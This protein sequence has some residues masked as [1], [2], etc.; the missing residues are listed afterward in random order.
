M[1]RIK[2]CQAS[3]YRHSELNRFDS[4]RIT[5]KVLEARLLPNTDNIGKVIGP[6]LHIEV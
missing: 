3:V 2:Y 6:R 4:D 1:D 5:H